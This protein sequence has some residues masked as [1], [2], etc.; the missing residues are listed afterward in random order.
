MKEGLIAPLKKKKISGNFILGKK[1]FKQA[2]IYRL[3]NIKK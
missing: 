3:I 1:E 2:K